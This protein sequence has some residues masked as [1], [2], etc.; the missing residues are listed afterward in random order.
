MNADGCAKGIH[1]VF[2]PD[3]G[4][5][6]CISPGP[7]LGAWTEQEEVRDAP[8]VYHFLVRPLRLTPQLRYCRG[9]IASHLIMD[10]HGL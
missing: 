3:S 10:D 9:A 1:S 6:R 4:S 5:I 8:L 7:G 2:S